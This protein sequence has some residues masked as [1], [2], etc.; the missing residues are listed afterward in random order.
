MSGPRVTTTG[1]QSAA[2]ISAAVPPI[3]WA[4][5]SGTVNAIT[6]AFNPTIASVTDGFPVA[7]RL[8]GTN[9]STTPTLAVDGTGVH[10]IVKQFNEALEPGDLPSEAFFRFN[11]T[12]NTWVLENPATMW[13]EIT[14]WAIAG[15]SADAITVAY[16]PAH[17]SLKDG[18]LLGIRAGA[19]NATTAPTIAVD[20]LTARILYKWGKQALLA[21]DIF[22]ANH[23][24]IV[25]YHVD[26]TPWF[27]LLNPTTANP[28]DPTFGNLAKILTADDVAG[29]NGNSAQPWFATA[30]G[31]TVKAGA[32]AFT[33][34]LYL[35]R[36]AGNTS[37]TTGTLFGGTATI[38]A[39]AGISR[40]NDGDDTGNTL[41]AFKS[42]WFNAATVTVVK[43][44]STSTTEQIV[45]EV[46]GTVVFSGGGTFIPQYQFSA[47]PGGAGTAKKGSY[48]ALRAINANPQGTWA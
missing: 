43:G 45:L 14:E 1:L 41:L 26:T 13:R 36:A 22:G 42:L 19:A 37:H 33:G 16:T 39:I 5:A 24:I 29:T 48:F 32:Y 8:S 4:V 35:S 11:G 3:Q 25:R 12:N 27:E 10:T 9:T 30:G 6:A 40:G 2:Q 38:T 46:E 23:E 31:V 18:Q 20:T 28:A 15:G 47:T 21:G 7:V 17:G 44:A 34:K